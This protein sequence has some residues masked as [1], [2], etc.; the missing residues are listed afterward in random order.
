[1]MLFLLVLL[2]SCNPKFDFRCQDQLFYPHA[3][4]STYST[5]YSDDAVVPEHLVRKS[6]VHEVIVYL[7]KY[8]VTSDRRVRSLMNESF[9]LV[10]R[11]RPTPYVKIQE[12]FNVLKEDWVDEHCPVKCWRMLERACNKYSKLFTRMSEGVLTPR[13]LKHLSRCAVRER[14]MK[15]C[16]SFGIEKLP[17]PKYLKSYILLK[18]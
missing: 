3:E 4:F 10:W 11:S 14:L 12:L 17:I 8:A 2:F 18:S 5:C 16:W 15:S 6:V 7:L 1:M 13:S 9:H